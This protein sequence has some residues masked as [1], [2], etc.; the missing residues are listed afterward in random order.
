MVRNSKSGY[1]TSGADY[2]GV[3]ITCIDNANG[4]DYYE[5][6]CYIMAGAGGA[7]VL[8]NPA[9]TYFQGHTL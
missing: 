7:S 6:Y 1:M 8:S 4:T 3:Q 9:F 2:S 5:V